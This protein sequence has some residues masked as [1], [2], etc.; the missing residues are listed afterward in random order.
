MTRRDI[1]ALT[2]IRGVAAIGVATYHAF[3]GTRVF[4]PITSLID[5]AYLAVDL[6]FVL[7][8]FVMMLTYG[9]RFRARVR[10]GDMRD[11]LGKRVARIYPLYAFVTA[12]ILVA[13]FS[14]LARI[15]RPGLFGLVANVLLV[16]AWGLG[17]GISVCGAAWS[18]STEFAA[19]LVFPLLSRASARGR[20]ACVMLGIVASLLLVLVAT[21]PSAVLWEA[22]PA[23]GRNGPLDV[24]IGATIFP[25]LRCFGGFTLG[26]LAFVA[27][28]S[29]AAAPLRATG[30]ADLVLVIVLALLARTDADVLIVLC[31]PI[32]VIAL[33]AENSLAARALASPPVHWLG[34]VSYSVYLLHQPLQYALTGS[35]GGLLGG[36]P[37][38]F[39]LAR[40][41]V[42][43]VVVGLAAPCF[44]GIER[45]GRVWLRRMTGK[46]APPIGA[47][48]AAP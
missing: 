4:G 18:I 13:E 42:L 32:L 37:H 16:Q 11:F 43:L 31:F 15:A 40:L 22:S 17:V 19:Y 6:F 38:A 39:T 46:P 41:L 1:R 28:P 14:G 20:A 21:R 2:G 45:P 23:S 26:V 48:P 30:A 34:I 35:M 29:R 33:A 27:W 47:E 7:S 9:E 36:A 3:A 10:A 25:L 44:Y 24:F 5:H 12:I 8:G